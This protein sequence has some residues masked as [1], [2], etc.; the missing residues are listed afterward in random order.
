M[1]TTEATS[2]PAFP[3]ENPRMLEDG[4]LFKQHAGLTKREYFAAAALQGMLADPNVPALG[5]GLSDVARAAVQCAD[6]LI[7]ALKG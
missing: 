7:A 1:S 3:L 6:D 2:G 5:Y 4:T